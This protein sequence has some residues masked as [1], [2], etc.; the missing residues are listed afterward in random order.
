MISAPPFSDP[1]KIGAATSSDDFSG[2]GSEVDWLKASKE[3]NRATDSMRSGDYALAVE[4]LRKAASIYPYDA[5]YYHNLGLA[6][7]HLGRLDESAS[8]YR[9][10]L[11]MDGH[12]WDTWCNLGSVLFDLKRY[13]DARKAFQAAIEN[14]P[15]GYGSKHIDWY[16]QEIT[17]MESLAGLQPRA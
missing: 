3:Y 12:R 17:R 4:L 14:R 5:D 15:N 11:A 7:K 6:Y 1:E 16:L 9:Q 10:A 8:A 13:P 2:K